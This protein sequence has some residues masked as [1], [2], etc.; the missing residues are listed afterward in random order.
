MK[1]RIES[2]SLQIDLE[3]CVENAGGRY[4]M[5]IAVSQRLREL[6]RRAREAGTAYVTPIDAL[7]EMQEGRINMVTYLAKVK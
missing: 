6:K 1:P 5:V 3:K 2:R 4:D 7:L